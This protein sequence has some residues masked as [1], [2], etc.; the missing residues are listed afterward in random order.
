MSLDLLQSQIRTLKCPFS[1]L[2]CPG[3]ACNISN[4][5]DLEYDFMKAI[6]VKMCIRD[7]FDSLR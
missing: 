2:L 3:I 4:E 1:L 6:S 7:R 5:R